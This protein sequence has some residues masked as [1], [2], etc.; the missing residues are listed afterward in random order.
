MAC[1][2]QLRNKM[3]T[4]PFS[5][6]KNGNSEYKELLKRVETRLGNSKTFGE[7]KENINYPLSVSKFI[8]NNVFDQL[9]KIWQGEGGFWDRFPSD[10]KI[11]DTPTIDFFKTKCWERYITSPNDLISVFFDEKGSLNW[12]FI[13]IADVKYVS[14]DN[15]RGYYVINE[16]IYSIGDKRFKYVTKDSWG[17]YSDETGSIIFEEN[18]DHN[19]GF[20]TCSFISNNLYNDRPV[21]RSNNITDSLGDIEQ[22]FFVHVASC[23]IDKHSL[24]YT[25]VAGQRG[26][27]FDDG[28]RYCSDGFLKIRSIENDGADITITDSKGAPQRCHVCGNN[29]MGYGSIV[30]INSTGLNASDLSA[31]ISNAVNFTNVDTD[32]L[33][34]ITKRKTQLEN[35]IKNSIVGISETFNPSQQHNELRVLSTYENQ[36]NVIFKTKAVF[37]NLITMVD[38]KCYK[39]LYNNYITSSVDLGADFY[40]NSEDEYQRAIDNSVKNR[41]EGY[42]DN[43]KALIEVKYR[44]NTRKRD[45]EMLIYKLEKMI[46]PFQNMNN[47]QLIIMVQAGKVSDFDFFVNQN[48]YSLIEQFENEYKGELITDILADKQMSEKFKIVKT[49]IEKIWQQTKQTNL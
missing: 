23:M 14:F 6:F 45:R 48:F 39:M 25:I 15:V 47:D 31:L 2:M 46:V 36:L 43:K 16:I 26:C 5:D 12:Q 49:F 4:V 18:K 21:I 9:S 20:N 27:D 19:F 7:F 30:E 22:L 41:I 32:I 13:D 34:H 3:F 42:V 1:K 8:H 24:P 38:T 28:T 17:I 33:E 35:D 44:N 11:A 37:E 10:V 29:S 40:L